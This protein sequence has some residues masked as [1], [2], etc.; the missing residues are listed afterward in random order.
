[1]KFIKCCQRITLNMIAKVVQTRF[2]L[3]LVSVL[4]DLSLFNHTI[5]SFFMCV[6]YVFLCLCVY[7][8]SP[9]CL[10]VLVW[11]TLSCCVN[12]STQVSLE[13]SSKCMFYWK[14]LSKSLLSIYRYRLHRTVLAIHTNQ[15]LTGTD[16]LTYNAKIQRWP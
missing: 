11:T 8:V 4:V 13:H 5:I 2:A 15:S 16:L 1:M 12:R 9:L 3:W 10:C 6:A 14:Q 7:A